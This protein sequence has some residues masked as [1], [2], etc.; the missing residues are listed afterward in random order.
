MKKTYQKPNADVLVF[1][2]SESLAIVWEDLNA[3]NFAETDKTAA[4]ILSTDIN[5]VIKK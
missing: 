4:S 2:P 5:I 1:R 3:G